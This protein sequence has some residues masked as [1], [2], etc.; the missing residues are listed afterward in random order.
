MSFYQP[1]ARKFGSPAVHADQEVVKPSDAQPAAG[2]SRRRVSGV[3]LLLGVICIMLWIIDSL[4][5]FP[6]RT[7][8]GLRATCLAVECAAAIALI[9]VRFNRFYGLGQMRLGPWYLAWSA[10]S[11]GVATIGWSTS[12]SNITAQIREVSVLSALAVASLGLAFWVAGYLLGPGQIGLAVGRKL[13]ML[14]LPGKIPRLYSPSVPWILSAVSV[15]ARVCL[16]LLGRYAYLGDPEARINSPT[17][18]TQPLTIIGGF[19][20]AALVIAASDLAQHGGARRRLTLLVILL[21][22]VSFGLVSGMKEEFAL[23]ILSICIVFAV[24]RY[25]FP[26]KWALLGV[27]IFLV[28]I[29]PFNVAYREAVRSSSGALDTRDAVRAAPGIF[30]ATQEDQSLAKT[31]T[32]SGDYL[33]YRVSSIDSLAVTLQRTPDIIG[34]RSSWELLQMPMFGAIPRFVWPDKPVLQDAYTFNH[35]YYSMDRSIYTSAAILPQGDLYRYGGLLPLAIGM[36]LFGVFARLVDE[37]LHP[38]LDP[39]LAVLFVPLFPLIIK[40][41]AGVGDVLAQLPM[42]IIMLVLITR[43]AYRVSPGRAVAGR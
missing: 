37:R 3:S 31:I 18:Y 24:A 15:L 27:G 9:G 12:R 16:I 26:F 5:Y 28:V 34:Y 42:T 30:A 41:E 36:M 23:I 10:L 29:I 8:I 11:L 33:L 21:V 22:E 6:D 4:Y 17:F 2:L 20:A 14:A 7:R 13:A 25:R 1:S 43:L 39:R 40:S 19:G 35:D 32:D 38:I